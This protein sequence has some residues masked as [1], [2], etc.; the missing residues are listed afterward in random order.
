VLFALSWKS[1]QLKS[2]VAVRNTCLS[3]HS[4]LVTKDVSHEE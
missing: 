4:G 1:Q 2:S 3:P